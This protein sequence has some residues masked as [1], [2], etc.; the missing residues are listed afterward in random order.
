MEKVSPTLLRLFSRYS[1]WYIARNFH[2]VRLS[3]SAPVPSTDNVPIVIY[4]NHASWWDPLVGLLLAN[5][6]WPSRKHFA[7]IDAGALKR[8][9]MLSRL[10]FFG[11]ELNSPRGAA[12]FLRTSMAILK[13]PASAL[14]ITGEGQFRDPRV[15]PVELRPGLGHLARRSS[16][17][18]VP[19][20]IEY[21]FWEERFPEALCRFG[22]PI[23]GGSSHL[24]VADWTAKLAL[25]MLKNQDALAAESIGRKS[26]DFRTILR[27]HVG[28]NVFYDAWRCAA[29]AL[30]GERFQKQH[31][32][33]AP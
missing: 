14:W 9:P 11:V 29:A 33:Q 2:A 24:A 31:G 7:P 3:I 17:A 13:S 26:E 18:F 15:R 16:A 21:P 8:Y 19:L 23:G 27:G 28:V 1:K 10:G 5:Q 25:E 6:F 30:K 4:L 32:D 12:K 22:P 20:A